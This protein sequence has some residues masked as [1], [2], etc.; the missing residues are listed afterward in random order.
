MDKQKL[1]ID[2]EDVNLGAGGGSQRL[3]Q[4]VF[5]EDGKNP[6]RQDSPINWNG[7]E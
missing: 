5:V 1:R 7:F 2:T 3:S 4:K 6:Q